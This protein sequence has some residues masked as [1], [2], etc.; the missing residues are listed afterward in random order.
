MKK[1]LLIFILILECFCLP[2]YAKSDKTLNVIYVNE[3]NVLFP[4]NETLELLGAKVTAIS[5]TDTFDITYKGKEY[6]G[7]LSPEKLLIKN[8]STNEYIFLNPMGHIGIFINLNGDLYIPTQTTERLLKAFNMKFKIDKENSIVEFFD[9]KNQKYFEMQL[10]TISNAVYAKATDTTISEWAQPD[11]EDAINRNIVPLKN[12]CAYQ[13]GINRLETCQLVAEF[14][15]LHGFEYD[16]NFKT[17][18]SDTSDYSV[19][20]LHNLGIIDGI[21]ETEFYPYDLI[22]REEAA[23]ILA[24]LYNLVSVEEN[25]QNSDFEYADKDDCSDWALESIELLS[26]LNIFKG[27]EFGNFNPKNNITKEQLIVTLHRLNQYVEY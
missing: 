27:D 1:L 23:K 17:P 20:M 8:K 12:Q 25:V 4:L 6:T 2:T 10:K 19:V 22:T 14:L 15:I 16:I 9:L 21:T 5:E 7:E 3:A 11:V 18:F 13:S 24:N 26:T